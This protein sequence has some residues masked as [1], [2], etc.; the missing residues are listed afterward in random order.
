MEL[1]EYEDEAVV[2]QPGEIVSNQPTRRHR[3]V[4]FEGERYY[5]GDFMLLKLRCGLEA[6]AEVVSIWESQHQEAKFRYKWYWFPRQIRAD[7]PAIE[8]ESTDDEHEVLQGDTT[9]TGPCS[10][11]LRQCVVLSTKRFE[12]VFPKLPAAV[13][14]RVKDVFFCDHEFIYDGMKVCPL[15]RLLLP[16]DPVPRDLL[17]LAGMEDNYAKRRRACPTPTLA[18]PRATRRRY[19]WSF[20]P[21]SAHV[22]GGAPSVYTSCE[23]PPYTVKAQLPIIL[24]LQAKILLTAL[25]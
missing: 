12:E 8:V 13:R 7:F 19:G 6:V 17:R 10:M 20:G 23:T 5:I 4:D 9:D 16:G 15:D 11:I 21:V 25:Q 1:D 14:A 22:E 3:A 2:V 18:T 24:Q